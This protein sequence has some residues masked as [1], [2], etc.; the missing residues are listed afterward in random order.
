MFIVLCLRSQPMQMTAEMSLLWLALLLMHYVLEHEN[1]SAAC[2]LWLALQGQRWPNFHLPRCIWLS[3]GLCLWLRWRFLC[4][5]CYNAKQFYLHR[6]QRAGNLP[7]FCKSAAYW[8]FWP[9]QKG[10]RPQSWE[11]SVFQIFKL[12]PRFLPFTQPKIIFYLCE[13]P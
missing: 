4:R 13:K 12:S 5:L 6:Q 9:G 11:L 10:T 3:S 1:H 8:R 2:V 7:W